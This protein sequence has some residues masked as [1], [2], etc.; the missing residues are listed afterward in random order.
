MDVIN[1]QLKSKIPT[2]IKGHKL[3]EYTGRISSSW[4]EG[5]FISSMKRVGQASEARNLIVK[6]L[7]E[8]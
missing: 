5:F 8:T 1:L 3:D 4:A 6:L 7:D 2:D